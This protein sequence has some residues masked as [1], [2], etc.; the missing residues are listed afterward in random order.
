MVRF[1]LDE[2]VARAVALG[3]RRHG[4]NVVRAQEVGLLGAPDEQHLEFAR[5]EG[6]VLVTHDGDFLRLHSEGVAHAGIAYSEQDALSIGEVI[7]ALLLI[8]QAIAPEEMFGQ[9]EYLLRM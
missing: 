8:Y 2:H 5:Q 9:I 6:R 3:L 1:Y 4:I 7:A